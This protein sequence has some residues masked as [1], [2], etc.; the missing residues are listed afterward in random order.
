V[1]RKFVIAGTGTRGDLLP[2]LAIADELLSR[3]RDC[4]V[5]GNAGIEEQARQ[6]GVPFTS[7]AP[8]QTNNLGGIEHNFGS[9]VFPSYAPI[10]DFVR[11]ELQRGSELVFVNS[12]YYAAT[13]LLAERYQLPLC[14]FT[15]APYR[16]VSLERPH[17][18]WCQ[19]LNGPFGRSVRRYALPQF[20][21]R[22]Y[23]QPY[24]LSGVNAFRSQLGLAPLESSRC[25]EQ[26]VTHQVCLFPEWYCP[27]AP[28]W[29]ANVDCVGFPLPS[30]RGS[31]PEFVRRWLREHPRPIVF[32]PGTGVSD[33]Q[34]FFAHARACCEQ[35]GKPGIFLSPS[36]GTEGACDP[37]ILHL[38][39]LELALLLP[40]ASLLVHHGGIGTTARAFEAGIPQLISPQAFDQ[41]DNAQRVVE[42]GA[43]ALLARERLSGDTLAQAAARLL[44]S[45]ETFAVAR[46]L[47]RRCV[48]S[49]AIRT[50]ADILEQQF[51]TAAA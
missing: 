35:L 26:L 19:R 21:E 29:P 40:H 44:A 48:R 24:V 37:R 23:S 33:V 28:D 9:H 41:P 11:A 39:H 47:S 36:F 6:R 49:N 2:M 4:H 42:L 22:R 3:G 50:F 18:P 43:G 5:L 31:L 10:A 20:Y 34:A 1:A 16:M 32:T 15:L 51:L 45:S 7:V 14:R 12:E 46:E 8:A 17:W 25:L 30:P 27:K 38:P 13:T